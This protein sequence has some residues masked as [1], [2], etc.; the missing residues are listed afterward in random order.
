[1]LV[2]S[3]NLSQS[4]NY[5]P[6]LFCKKR[7]KS[8]I[9]CF[10]IRTQQRSGVASTMFLRSQ[11]I[12]LSLCR[13]NVSKIYRKK[14]ILPDLVGDDE[15]LAEPLQRS[16]FNEGRVP[17]CYTVCVSVYSKNA[18]T[19]ARCGGGWCGLAQWCRIAQFGCRIAPFGCRI[20]QSGVAE[21]SSG[22]A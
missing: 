11:N 13:W 20:A 5:A 6:Y 3:F 4:F 10:C 22:V 2:S 21:L 7:F 18:I 15:I 19:L 12:F 1:M 8:E 16:P 14:R 17:L 9:I